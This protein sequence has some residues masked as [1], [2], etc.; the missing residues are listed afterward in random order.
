MTA[1]RQSPLP[2]FGT[3]VPLALAASLLAHASLSIAADTVVPPAGTEART[4]ELARISGL[5]QASSLGLIASARQ[6]GETAEVAC[7]QAAGDAPFIAAMSKLLSAVLEPADVD[8]A[9]AFY[10]STAGHKYSEYGRIA[11]LRAVGADSGE[12]LPV[13]SAE[14]IAAVKAFA[15]SPAGRKLISRDFGAR[16]QGDRDLTEAG[17]GLVR[18]C[19]ASGGK[20]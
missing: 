8:A 3:V 5:A 4:T 11:G 16:L 6:Q 18:Q 15:A 9:I 1:P 12:A 7:L 19:R 17:V 2:L 14:E 13:L 10:D 20:P